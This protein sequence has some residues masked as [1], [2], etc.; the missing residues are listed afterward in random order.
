LAISFALPSYAQQKDVADP[1]T[2]QKILAL[3]KALDEGHN[4]NDPAAIAV[5]YTRDGVFLTPEGPIVGRQ[6]IQTWFTDL[7]QWWHPKNHIGKFDGNAVHLI[8]TAGNEVWATGEWSETGLGKNGELS[9][10]RAI[11]Q[12]FMFARAIIGR[13]RWTPGTVPRTVS[14]SSTRV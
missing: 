3:I 8:G 5:V 13:S 14:Y 7:F 10:S 4:N 6:A 11:G 12:T 2:T 1:Q 9:Q